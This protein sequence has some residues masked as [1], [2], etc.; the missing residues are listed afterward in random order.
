MLLRELKKLTGSKEHN[1]LEILTKI[2]VSTLTTKEAHP[3]PQAMG[4][5]ILLQITLIIRQ[6]DV[7][8]LQIKVQV[9]GL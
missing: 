6:V 1:M 3:E 4:R 7:L 5:E 9:E 8:D 2:L